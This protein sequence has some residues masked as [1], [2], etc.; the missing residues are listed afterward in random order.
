ME[1]DGELAGRLQTAF[2]GTENTLGV[3]ESCTGGLLGA[4]ITATPGASDY[5]L[6]GI[7]AYHNDVKLQALGVSRESL[8]EHGAVSDP[9]AREMASGLRDRFGATWSVSITGTAGPGGGTEE[10]PVGTVYIGVS[11]A[12]PWGSGTSATGA[13]RYVFEGDRQAV[14]RQTVEQAIADLLETYEVLS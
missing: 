8:D 12:G 6:G 5:F 14:R 13:E 4:T 11:H 1:L 7:T 9:V 3:A 2:S 10:T